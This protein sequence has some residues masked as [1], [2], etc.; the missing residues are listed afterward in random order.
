MPIPMTPAL[1]ADLER[2]ELKAWGALYRDA[3]PAASGACGLGIRDFPPAAAMWMSKI[4][5]LACN[6]V[7][8]LGLDQTPDRKVIKEIVAT[9][10]Q[11]MVPRFF[12][13]LAPLVTVG[14]TITALT[15]L[16]FVP[17]NNWVR[18]VRD[19]SPPGP[20][21]TKVRVEQIDAARAGDFA[22]IL[23]DGFGWNADLAVAVEGVVGRP[24]WRCYLAF[25]GDRPVATA[26][27]VVDGRIG[28]LSFAATLPEARG[29]GGH[30]ALL[31]RRILD[32]RAAGCE[33]LCV[34]TAEETQEKEAPSYRNVLRAGFE[35][36]YVR[37]NY[38]YKFKQRDDA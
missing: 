19:A 20:I 14:P 9:Y 6:R 34:E 33:V 18:L 8:G 10:D 28:W 5:V 13:Q 17:Y 29:L 21:P 16:G 22:R 15:D 4:D 38:L 3:T 27:L 11:A 31:G 23:C 32:A 35:V 26:A 2:A 7:V 30:T 1:V 25:D 12:V 36:G 37:P 24:G